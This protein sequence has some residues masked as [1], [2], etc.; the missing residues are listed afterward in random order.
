MCVCVCVCVCICVRVCENV[1]EINLRLRSNKKCIKIKIHES[2]LGSVD[3]IENISYFGHLF[4]V[5][6]R[7]RYLKAVV[8]IDDVYRQKVKNGLVIS[9]LI[10]VCIMS[11]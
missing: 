11:V 2:I 10:S 6:C 5:T 8:I 7:G 9:I 3:Q 1:V 4:Q